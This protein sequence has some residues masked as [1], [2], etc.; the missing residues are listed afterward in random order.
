[1]FEPL[2][3]LCISQHTSELIKDLL[4]LKFSGNPEEKK[5]ELKEIKKS[6]EKTDKPVIEKA[7][8]V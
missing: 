3:F 5:T 7:H 1:M 4:S 8:E 2:K 6:E